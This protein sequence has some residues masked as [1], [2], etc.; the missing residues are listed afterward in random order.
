MLAGWSVGRRTRRRMASS[1]VY[2]WPI[3]KLG[4]ISIMTRL[5]FL[6]AAF[7]FLIFHTWPA[8]ATSLTKSAPSNSGG[9]VILDHDNCRLPNGD[10]G[11]IHYKGDIPVACNSRGP[12][13]VTSDLLPPI[14]GPADPEA[15]ILIN[16]LEPYSQLPNSLPIGPA[17]QPGTGELRDPASS[18]E[19]HPSRPIEGF[20]RSADLGSP[21][22][23]VVPVRF[24]ASNR[25]QCEEKLSAEIPQIGGELVPM[26]SNGEAFSPEAYCGRIFPDIGPISPP[27]NGIG[28]CHVTR[29]CASGDACVMSALSSLATS[30][31]ECYKQ[32][33]RLGIDRKNPSRENG[34]CSWQ[35]GGR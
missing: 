1:P 12:G 24:R 9:P 23:I 16:V 10:L 30:E 2:E 35:T 27:R 25:A 22:E 31:G 14:V 4:G 18:H 17:T 15:P 11:S 29:P 26:E 28:N 20:A 6:F 13:M 21:Q 8:T 19:S 34:S 32:C 5:L 3:E 33:E 7:A